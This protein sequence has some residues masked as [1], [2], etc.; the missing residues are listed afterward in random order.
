MRSFRVQAVAL[1]VA[2]AG[3]WSIG[4]C[5]LQSLQAGTIAPL[6]SEIVANPSIAVDSSCLENDQRFDRTLGI[7][8]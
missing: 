4:T 6:T 8:G 5:L 1:A 2:G 3:S 7:V